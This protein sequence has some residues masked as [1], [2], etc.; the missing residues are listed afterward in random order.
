[1]F[2]EDKRH[3]GPALQEAA[4]CSRGFLV[5]ETYH[6]KNEKALKYTDEELLKVLST[7]KVVRRNVRPDMQNFVLSPGG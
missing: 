4:R 6:V 3:W 2:L 1:M 7:Y 5:V